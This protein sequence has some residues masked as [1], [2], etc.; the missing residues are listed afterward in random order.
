[1]AIEHWH[2]TAKHLREGDYDGSTPQ[3]VAPITS[4]TVE[5]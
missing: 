4:R 5:C 3:K 1:M 2:P